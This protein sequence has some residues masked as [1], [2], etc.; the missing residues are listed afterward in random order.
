MNNYANVIGVSEPVKPTRRERAQATRSRM[1]RAAHELFCEHGYTGTRMADVAQRAGVAV[2]TVYFAFHTKAELLRACYTHAV[3]GESDPLPPEAQ[4]W[5]AALLASVT[6]PEA[7]RWF[8]KGNGAIVARVGVL[9]DVV[10]AAVH[11]PDAAAIRAH[12][13]Q[14]RRAGYGRIVERLAS[15]FGL[16]EGL[17]LNS[18]TEVM[19]TL[20]GAA[21]Y[22]S[23]VI[24]YGWTHEAYVDWVTAA[25][26]DALLPQASTSDDR[27]YG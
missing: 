16:R 27:I 4:P 6:G 8:A 9:D 19:L 25:L 12:S 13:E 17:D 11:E 23:L 26:I 3:L 5:H 7:L 14:L 18:A 1:L 10:R 15:A 20:G 21:V 24:D 2:Q 22:R